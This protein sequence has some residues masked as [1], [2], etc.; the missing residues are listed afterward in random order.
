M[1]SVRAVEVSAP[2]DLRRFIEL[3]WRLYGGDPNWVPPLRRDVRTAF[4][5][6][7][8]PFFEH[9]EA[10]PFLAVRNDGTVV[11]RICAIRNRR[12]EQFHDEPVGFFGWM[13]CE[14]D[15]E[16]FA[17]L[18]GAVR[19]WLGD[20][21]LSAVRGPVSFSINDVA[22][23]LVE[24]DPGPPLIMMP[25]NPPWY[26]DLLEGEGFGKAK[27]LLAWWVSTPGAGRSDATFNQSYVDRAERIVQRRHKVTTRPIN[28]KRFSEEV[29]RI[30]RIYNKSWDLNWGFV[31]MTGA[32]MDHLAGEL[33]QV[34]EPELVLFAEDE[35]GEPIG[36]AIALRDA[37]PMFKA[38][39]GRLT[40]WGIARAM[41][42]RKRVKVAR[43]LVLG[44]VP[45]WR[46]RGVDALLI[47]RLIRG[48]MA[49]G[50]EG[51]ELSWILEDNTLMNR[52]IENLGG[53]LSR[54][55]RIYE[56]SGWGH[57]SL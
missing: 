16:A 21:G 6:A 34:I 47:S 26:A 36:M 55:Y 52:A 33:K 24:G 44:V 14:K 40:P 57:A 54:R 41:R 7:R 30:R 27:D 29:A 49:L 38:M 39:N 31:P 17:V 15:P 23:L 10:R 37:N 18:A 11:G 3:P 46:G 19:G 45:E 4:N 50:I 5:P 42:I 25:Y 22:G 35:D 9:S 2:Q 20:R 48:G 12:H 32:E 51:G 43:V 28:L 13:E 1:G 8:N 53:K 56:A